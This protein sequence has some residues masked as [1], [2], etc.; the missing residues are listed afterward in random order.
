MTKLIKSLNISLVG[1]LW[2]NELKVSDIGEYEAF[3]AE[4]KN[5]LYDSDNMANIAIF[6][7]KDVACVNWGEKECGL[8]LRFI[9]E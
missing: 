2:P 4:N 8:S 9:E 6:D 1:F 3:W 5:A 7:I